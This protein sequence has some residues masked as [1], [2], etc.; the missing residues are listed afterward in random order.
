[1]TRDGNPLGH[2]LRREWSTR[3]CIVQGTALNENIV[4]SCGK[5]IMPRHLLP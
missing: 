2:I 3:I 4:M 5:E 1:M